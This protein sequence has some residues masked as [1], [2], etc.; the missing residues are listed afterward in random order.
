ML[1][2]KTVSY[3]RVLQFTLADLGPRRLMM[4]NGKRDFLLFSFSTQN[5][6][7]ISYLPNA[8]FGEAARKANKYMM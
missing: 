6:R 1:Q 3:R 2:N 4:F 7:L 5:L 8:F